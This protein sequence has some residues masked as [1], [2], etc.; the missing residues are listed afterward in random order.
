MDNQKIGS[1]IRD[2]R[3]E[4]DMTQKDLADLLHITDR[5]V[6]KWERGLNA[7]DIALLEP[8]AEVLD[9]T[10]GELIRGTRGGEA[11]TDEEETKSILDYSKSEVVRKVSHTRKKYLGLLVGILALALLVSGFFL[12][13]SGVLFRVDTKVS[14]DG[15]HEI[16]VYNKDWI[17]PFVIED[18]LWLEELP[19][20][21]RNHI[22]FGSRERTY[23]G[24][25]WSPDSQKYVFSYTYEH[26]VDGRVWR[27]LWLR[28]LTDDSLD[29]F[30]LP[31]FQ[32]DKWLAQRGLAPET[33]EWIKVDYQFLQWGKDSV[34][35][36]FYYSFTDTV[37]ENH[38]GYFWYNYQT[39]QYSGLVEMER[40]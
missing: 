27:A 24:V 21:P 19:G 6:S 11:Q 2:L 40:T 13:R 12:L 33:E 8:L 16:R 7:P 18:D 10:V 39:R 35:M 38:E 17:S 32:V 29:D 34:T 5:A 28:D 30:T 22:H 15:K 1:F 3:K 23:E 31:F 25:W 14:P 4:K 36:L 37:G 20:G 9:V 26:V